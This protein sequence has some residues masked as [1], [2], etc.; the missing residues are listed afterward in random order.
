MRICLYPI[1][2]DAA[3]VSRLH[4]FVMSNGSDY[5]F[6]SD[7]RQDSCKVY[8]Y[9][10]RTAMMEAATCYMNL[11]RGCFED[12]EAYQNVMLSAQNISNAQKGQAFWQWIMRFPAALKHVLESKAFLRYLDW[13]NMW[14]EEQNKKHRHNLKRVEDVL[15]LCKERLPFPAAFQSIRIVLNPIKCD[16]S[17]D[18]HIKDDAFVFCLG[19]FREESVIH[20]F[21]HHAVHPAVEHRKDEILSDRIVN[22]DLDDSY[23]LDG[24]D[25][26]KLNVFEEAMVRKLTD[27]ILKGTVPANVD[28]FLDGEIRNL[29]KR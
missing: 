24:G 16:Y 23:Y 25:A 8:P 20:E 2:R 28:V 10:P 21:V 3:A 11:S 17:S 4:S 6:F 9:W 26:G 29:M 7:A 5:C 19:A 22:F 1:E 12:F 15:A 27:K 18:C 14:I 13:E